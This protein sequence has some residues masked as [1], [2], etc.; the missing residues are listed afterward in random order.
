MRTT[1]STLPITTAPLELVGADPG[2]APR[3]Q[4][5]TSESEQ[6]GQP[7][8]PKQAAA[9]GKSVDDTS[10]K[11]EGIDDEGTVE[12]NGYITK[13]LTSSQLNQDEDKDEAMPSV[14]T[15]NG[16]GKVDAQHQ[17][18]QPIP[19]HLPSASP[20]PQSAPTIA[21]QPPPLS[22]LAGLNPEADEFDPRRQQPRLNPEAPDFVPP[23]LQQS[24]PVPHMPSVFGHPQPRY[25]PSGHHQQA[26]YPPADG[27]QPG[28]YQLV[29]HQPVA[30]Q[31]Y[32][33][34]QQHGPPPPLPSQQ[35]TQPQPAIIIGGVELDGIIL[36]GPNL[37]TW[38]PDYHRE[39]RA[40]WYHSPRA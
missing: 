10:S 26:Y 35:P 1:A 29:H 36:Q 22:I 11:E 30:E 25:Y 9:D 4:E 20:A 27:G 40:G 5:A 31:G 32:P 23:Q 13:P 15:E 14:S 37:Q 17:T 2:E 33:Q 18:G 34:H 28:P 7:Q 19:P 6:S 3:Q 8:S 16:D 21:D 12:G 24:V 38:V 39:H